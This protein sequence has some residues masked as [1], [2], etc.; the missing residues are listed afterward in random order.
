MVLM[1]QRGAAV[2]PVWAAAVYQARDGQRRAG[3]AGRAGSL[4]EQLACA[5]LLLEPDVGAS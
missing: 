1:A 2:S 4:A 5:G 3:G